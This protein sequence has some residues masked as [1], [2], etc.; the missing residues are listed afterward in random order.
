MLS[1]DKVIVNP[2]IQG[3]SNGVWMLFASYY[4]FGM[5]YPKEA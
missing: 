3:F 1:L 2:H 5:D 4:I